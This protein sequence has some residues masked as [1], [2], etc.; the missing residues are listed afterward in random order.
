MQY[1]SLQYESQ[2]EEKII[3]II[4][5]CMQ[6]STTSALFQLRHCLADTAQVHPQLI[7]AAAI[8]AKHDTLFTC[9]HTP[10]ERVSLL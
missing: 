4:I 7:P 6:S 5:H 10:D 9:V 8:L 1:C 2:H 3:I